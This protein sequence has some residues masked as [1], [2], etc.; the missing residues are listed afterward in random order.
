MFHAS[1]IQMMVCLTFSCIYIRIA[2][3]LQAEVP[4]WRQA[5]KGY[6]VWLFSWPEVFW[7]LEHDTS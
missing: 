3:G 2:L 6:Q 5:E 1:S 4:D 7:Q